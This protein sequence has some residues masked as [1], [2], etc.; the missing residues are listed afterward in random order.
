MTTG[1]T[2]LT[3]RH[4]LT[5]VAWALGYA[6]AAFLGRL[7]IVDERSLSLVWPAAGVAVVWMLAQGA[8]FLSIDTAALALATYVVNT[9]TGASPELGL[10]FIVANVVQA[11]VVVLLLRRWAPHLWGAGGRDELSRV[12][13]LFWLLGAAAI[14]TTLAAT[15]GISGLALTGVP[16][17]WL[18]ALVW[19]GRNFCGVIAIAS[20]GLLLGER[21]TRPR[22]R[23]ANLAPSGTEV[24]AVFVT[25]GLLFQVAF[26]FGDLPLAFPLLITTVWAGLRL[27][28]LLS[29]VHSVMVGV[30]A[31]VYTLNGLGPF[32]GID[33]IEVG[34]LL[35]QLFVGMSVVTGLI[36]AIGHDERERLTRELHASTEESRRQA[37]LM[38][39]VFEKVS[40][41]IVLVGED[42]RLLMVNPAAKRTLGLGEGQS[43]DEQTVTR[44][45]GTPISLQDRPAMRAL[46]GEEVPEEDIVI[47]D[48]SE[49]TL[50][51][52]ANPLP[53]EDLGEQRAVIVYR[54]VTQQRMK[55]RELLSF[56]GV[57]AHDLKNP[58]SMAEGWT[59]ALDDLM[60][61]SLATG[62]DLDVA[63]AREMAQ[64]IGV[65]TTRMRGLI[66]DL[67]NHAMAADRQLELRPIDL[68][69]LVHDVASAR[70][71]L[72]HVT[73]GELP[74]V[75][76]DEVL[77]RQLLD[78]LIGNAVK[79]VAP[80]VTP[81]VRLHCDAPVV[82]GMATI[83]VD[84]N[85][86]GV[87]E[88]QHER[89]FEQFHRA[90]AADYKGTGLGLA[91]CER[92]VAR[93]GGRIWAQPGPDGVGTRFC[94][95][96]PVA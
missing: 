53:S 49:R 74:T 55:E 4:A 75:T 80:G 62:R 40:E 28:G 57:V 77:L 46:A 16:V 22:D 36:L 33:P 65:A 2:G 30:T 25:S 26:A 11:W 6:V 61:L 85:G 67:L 76:A 32:A 72:D 38:D 15:V 84:D 64:K 14:G 7:T 24:A 8:R 78:N 5:T 83:C 23:W 44:A 96:L 13:D 68:A 31:V 43:L 66:S 90:H 95:T 41:G 63:R 91:I 1:E 21:I 29:T 19:W 9:L 47:H 69:D 70:A 50:A 93:H 87:P 37:V 27:S 12:I 73:L 58:L 51:T 88:G 79:Y 17:D 18:S 20:L 45:D 34:A 92:I 81:H 42:G 71:S 54:D 10:V 82:D 35:A 52:S 56:A 89:I 48:T 3:V 86:I 39:T 59:E 94:F 60:S